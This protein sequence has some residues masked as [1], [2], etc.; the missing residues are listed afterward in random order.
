M[1][2]V[3]VN[4]LMAFILMRWTLFVKDVMMIVQLAP[5]LVNVKH[6]QLTWSK[7]KQDACH[8]EMINM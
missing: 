4:V 8:A 2:M 1:L 6:V 5:S 3:A 7:A